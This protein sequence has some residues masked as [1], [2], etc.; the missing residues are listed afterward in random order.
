M[1]KL[2]NRLSEFLFVGVLAVVTGA[3]HADVSDRPLYVGG[4]LSPMG[5]ITLSQ[6][7]ST[8]G[9]G[10]GGAL[11]VG[12]RKQLFAVEG[13][14]YYSLVS[15]DG[16]SNAH[17][18]GGTIDGLIFPFF[19]S[20]GPKLNEESLVN[21]LFEN[22]Y[23][24][25]GAGAQDT[26]SYPGVSNSS[27][28]TT[29]YQGG[30]GDLVPFRFGRYECGLRVEAIYQGGSRDRDSK[31]VAAGTPDVDAPKTF[32]SVIFSIGVQLPIGLTHEIPQE[33]PPPPPAVVPVEQ[34]PDSD[35]DGV[36]DNAD[37]C[38]DTPQGVKVD[39]RGCPVPA[40]PLPPPCKAPATGERVSLSG[41]G[42]GDMMTLRGV[43][44]EFDKTELT[45]NA[46]TIMDNVADELNAYPAIHIEIDGYTDNRGSDQYNRRLS[47]GRAA[48]ARDYLVAKGIAGD[49][50]S[51][52]GFGASQPVADNGTE[53][54]REQ[55]RRVVLKIVAGAVSAPQIPTDQPAATGS[56]GPSGN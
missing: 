23:L 37:Q 50:I 5:T 12:Y 21:R 46:K 13:R 52:A 35:G 10:Q 20:L 36:A 17:L 48:A 24:L 27:V 30:L 9:I 18:Y 2:Q 45:P 15:V 19:N 44:F 25:I 26:K 39:D 4:Y 7:S 14:G 3:A 29:I 47:A 31:D 53:E 32:N 40:A 1:N 49:R 54:G 42:T 6:G 22:A 51:A 41:C 8:L 38:P 11:A 16:G 34:A 43:N 33:A 55:N 56:A 28:G